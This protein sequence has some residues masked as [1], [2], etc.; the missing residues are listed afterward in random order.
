MKAGKSNPSFHQS[1]GTVL[2][3]G[4]FFGMLPVD[5]VLAKDE[6]V[7]KF[8]WKSLKTIYSMAFL[9][10]GTVESCLGVRRLLRLGFNINFAEG[11]LFFVTAMIRAFM[12]FRL[13]RNWNAIMKKWKMCE[14]AFLKPPYRVKGWS[15]GTK[16]KVISGI[17]ALLGTSKHLATL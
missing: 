12:I 6:S 7:L 10:F 1:I 13:A 15:L 16:V 17:V 3:Y 2:T 9:F 11:L 14:D 5:G 8:R 4:Q